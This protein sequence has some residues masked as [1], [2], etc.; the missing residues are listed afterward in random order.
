MSG[1]LRAERGYP[2]H[3]RRAPDHASADASRKPVLSRRVDARTGAALFIS[4]SEDHLM[5]P[6][7]Q[8]SKG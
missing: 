6:G 2:E 5:P 8:R 7:V 3:K 1:R 4:G